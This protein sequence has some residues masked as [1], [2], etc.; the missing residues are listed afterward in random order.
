MESR[1]RL[2]H[3]TSN[4]FSVEDRT[5]EDEEDGEGE[6][7]DEGEVQASPPQV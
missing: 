3:L 2:K 5:V 6:E 1:N 7:G 4:S